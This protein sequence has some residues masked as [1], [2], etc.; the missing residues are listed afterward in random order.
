[1][2]GRGELLVE[3]NRGTARAGRGRAFSEHAQLRRLPLECRSSVEQTSQAIHR[4]RPCGI[5]PGHAVGARFA[6]AGLHEHRRM[7]QVVIVRVGHAIS[8]TLRVVEPPHAQVLGGEHTDK[9]TVVGCDA[10]PRLEI[11][12]RQ[13]I[14]L[15]ALEQTALQGIARI[16]GREHTDHGEGKQDQQPGRQDPGA[17]ALEDARIVRRGGLACVRSHS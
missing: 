8:Q 1:M 9:V 4:C 13:R 7:P 11:R 12:D 16:G 6:D 3:Q 5:V 15:V 14:G 17:F 2:V 10:Q